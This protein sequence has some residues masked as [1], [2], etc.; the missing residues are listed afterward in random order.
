MVSQVTLF[1]N[2]FK[3]LKCTDKLSKGIE[4]LLLNAFLGCHHRYAGIVRCS[5]MQAMIS[6]A[7]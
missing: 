1:M 6:S 7:T 4:N 3:E 5:S 2:L